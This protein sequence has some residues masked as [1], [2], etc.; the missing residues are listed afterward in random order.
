III[1]AITAIGIKPRP[2]Y[3][4]TLRNIKYKIV[5]IAKLRIILA[6]RPLSRL[7][8]EGVLEIDNLTNN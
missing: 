7:C 8:H 4:S 5:R 3:A 6:V 1:D 2:I